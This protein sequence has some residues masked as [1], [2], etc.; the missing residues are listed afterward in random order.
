MK[1]KFFSVAFVLLV[2]VTLS[3]L[4]YSQESLEGNKRVSDIRVK[5]NSS[6]NTATILSKLK[7]KPGDQFE[8]IAL[9]KELKRLY[10]T[11]YFA[12]VFVETLDLPEGITVIFS[13]VEKPI[14]K[15]IKFKGNAR[16]KDARLTSK[17]SAKEE[18]LL[19]FH[20]LA[21]DVAELK[22]LYTDEGYSL[23]EVEYKIETDPGTGG[24]VVIF[25]INEGE[26]L[27]I[28]SIRIEGNRKLSDGQI[29]K[30]MSTK[31]MW[32]FIQ[33]GAFDEGKLQEDLE[34]IRTVY[35]SKG[36]LDA[37][38]TSKKEFLGTEKKILLTI[39]VEEGKEYLVG[40][41]SISG[42]LTFP[43]KELRDVLGLRS[44]DSFDYQKVKEDMEALREFYYNKGYMD[45]EVNIKHIYNPG[46][47][48]M[49]ITYDVQSHEEISV[50][51]INIVGN[52]KTK[53]KV[54]R[55]E[56]RLYP[57]DKY[58]G[59]KLKNSKER[60]YNMGFFED[61]YF[62]TV[63]AGQKDVKDLNVTVKETKTGELS[64][65]G[66]YSS[67]DAF[68]GFVQIRQ[69]NFDIMNFPFFT[70]SGQDLTIRAEAGSARTNYFLSWTDPWI[71][72][73]PVLFGFDL[74][75]EEQSKYGTS[76]Y[77]Y[78]ER[79]T[80]MS[81][82]L[83]KDLTDQL[84]TGVVYNLEEVKISDIP[85]DASIDL[86]NEEGENSLS[87]LTWNVKYD[88]RDNRYSPRKGSVSGMSLENAG[89]FLAGD[90]DF[91]KLYLYTSWYHSLWKEVV[92]EL[93]GRSGTI[94]SY[95]DSD[96]VPIY[97]RY[98]AGG[99]STIRGYSQRGIGPR[100][101]RDSNVVVGGNA[102]VIGNAEVTFPLFKSLI[103]GA[104][105]YDA[106]SVMEKAEEIF[107]AT[108][109]KMGTGVG[110]RVKTPIGPV[111]LDYGYP[112]TANEDEKKEGQFYFSVSHGF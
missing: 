94:E 26:V 22:N 28:K 50:G 39:T 99:A 95:G 67:V 16:L 93:K 2:S 101:A 6:I 21:Q 14:I 45:A 64:F 97:E 108:D 59:K 56:L 96:K 55:R 69:R 63:A 47:G 100:D 71:C 1:R 27:K 79:R 36:F 8:E 103:K 29:K 42:N 18:T 58:D 62:D 78:D 46:T 9:N 68:I 89:G 7:M 23:A 104:V 19:D 49:D 31:P 11:G 40:E 86:Q 65:G 73:Y 43:E 92:L 107:E 34:R 110:V 87:R 88:T 72:D 30:Y 80:G 44:G 53:D 82:K 37:K 74:Y 33:K 60:I 5:G 98:F 102:M 109:Y 20:I 32:L 4:G 83:G 85:E 41:T 112:L 111:N 70:G 51:K 91:V 25:E 90:K 84:S 15:K 35:R 10:A 3:F 54:I 81:L 57:G 106:G 66:G 13:V 76:G 48:K 12:D 75:R 52:T 77:D 24:A 17:I 38:I 61:V 105:F